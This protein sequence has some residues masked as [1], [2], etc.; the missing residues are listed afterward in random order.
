MPKDEIAGLNR[1][2]AR[3]HRSIQRQI[4]G[5]S[6]ADFGYEYQLF[7]ALFELV[8]LARRWVVGDIHDGSVVRQARTRVDDVHV[9][10]DDHLRVVQ[11]KG[12]AGVSWEEDLVAALWDEYE[13]PVETGSKSIEVCVGSHNLRD[14]MDR[15]KI[16]GKSRL[17]REQHNLHFVEVVCVPEGWRFR[18]YLQTDIRTN[19]ELLT[20]DD[21]HDDLIEL[22]PERPGHAPP[23]S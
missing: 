15:N 6:N 3:R 19:L 12:G 5:A 13:V 10:A 17:T 8:I 2:R 1:P 21:W 22:A 16:S 18:P 7:V 9:T 23:L 11:A 20:T 4:T 14:R